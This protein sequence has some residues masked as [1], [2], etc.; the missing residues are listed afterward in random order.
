MRLGKRMISVLMREVMGTYSALW[1]SRDGCKCVRLGILCDSGTSKDNG[2]CD[3]GL[4][5][6]ARYD[7][8][9]QMQW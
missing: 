2:D 5:G 8:I 4:H 7:G 1:K 9:L 3:V 6:E